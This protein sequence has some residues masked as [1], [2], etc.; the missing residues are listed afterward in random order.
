MTKAAVL[1][2]LSRDRLVPVVRAPSAESALQTIDALLQGGISIVEVTMTV[3][4]AVEVIRR[5]SR[6]FGDRILLG[7]GTVLDDETARACVDAGAQ[8]VVSPALDLE[9]VSA[10]N[11]MDIVMA[12]G[13]LTPTEILSAWRAGADIVKVFPCDAMGGPSYL[14]SLRAPLPH[15]PL[16]PTGG[17]N[18]DNLASFIAA[19]AVAVGVGGNLVDPKISHDALVER[20]RA[21][22]DRI[23]QV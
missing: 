14:K 8:F 5:I 16:M 11:A 13:A 6:Q 21:F 3:P 18:L 17:V 2:W 7:A 9:T 12:P 4:N 23:R 22:V 1:Q 19:G 20:A 15:V 10:C